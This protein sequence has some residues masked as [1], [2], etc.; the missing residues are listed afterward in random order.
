[1]KK[2]K[3]TDKIILPTSSLEHLD[4]F[5]IPAPYFFRITTEIGLTKY[6][7]VI[8]FTAPNRTVYMS[9]TL[10]EDLFI[11]VGDKVQISCVSIPTGEYVKFKDVGKLD[12]M[13]LSNP[14][15]VLE[16][17]LRNKSTLE[18]NE[19]IIIR[20][21]ELD[22]VYELEVIETKPGNVIS[23]IDSNIKVEFEKK[24]LKK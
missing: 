17:T 13:K 15:C 6:S 2:L 18:L 3:N 11:V 1:M 5:R 24:N 16:R 14:T 12:F 23:L 10:I 21:P 4:K 9:R 22:C 20:I 19:R 8:E 7:G